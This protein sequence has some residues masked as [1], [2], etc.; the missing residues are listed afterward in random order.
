MKDEFLY[1]NMPKVDE[2]LLEAE[3]STYDFEH[4][5]SSDFENNMHDIIVRQQAVTKSSGF[6]QSVSKRVAVILL[7]ILGVTAGS[8]VVVNAATDGQL[9]DRI[10]NVFFYTDNGATYNFQYSTGDEQ[11]IDIPQNAVHGYVY[12]KGNDTYILDDGTTISK[13]KLIFVNEASAEKKD[14]KIEVYIIQ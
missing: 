9:F 1:R 14:A 6:K 12:Y 8:A 7:C 13:D 5:F 3:K 11:S 4:T 10:Y 2:K